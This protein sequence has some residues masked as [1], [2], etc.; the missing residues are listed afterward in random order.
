MFANLDSRPNF[1]SLLPIARVVLRERQAAAAPGGCGALPCRPHAT[2]NS[3]TR[4]SCRRG[5]CRW[6]RCRCE[7]CRC[8]SERCRRSGC[9][10]GWLVARARRAL[11]ARRLR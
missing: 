8:D 4:A 6:G 10:R 1:K 5:P 2:C 9:R 11:P 3:V 7:R